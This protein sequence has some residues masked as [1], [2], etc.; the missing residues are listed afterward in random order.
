MDEIDRENA[1][2]L[3]GQELFPRRPLP[4]GSGIDPGIMSAPRSTRSRTAVRSCSGPVASPPM[5][6]QCPLRLVMGGPDATIVGAAECGPVNVVAC[7]LQHPAVPDRR[8]SAS[9]RRPGG[10][11]ADSASACRAR[12]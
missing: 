8:E 1:A 10:D 11:L 9:G 3:R 7:L 4:A 2:G 5:F 12:L 6:A